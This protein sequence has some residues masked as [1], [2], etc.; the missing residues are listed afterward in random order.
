MQNCKIK[1]FTAPLLAN[2]PVLSGKNL[3]KNNSKKNYAVEIRAATGS[4][5]DLMISTLRVG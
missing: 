1:I 4:T 5:F 2:E 3:N